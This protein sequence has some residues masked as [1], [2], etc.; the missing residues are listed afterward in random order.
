MNAFCTIQGWWTTWFSVLPGDLEAAFLPLLD[1]GGGSSAVL[2]QLG[3]EG[4]GSPETCGMV[5][6]WQG[7]SQAGSS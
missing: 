2:L 7:W 1:E 6:G 5:A 4:S 3:V